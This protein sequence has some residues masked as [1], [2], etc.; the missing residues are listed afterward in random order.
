ASELVALRGGK[1]W[2][3]TYRPLDL[4]S[5]ETGAA[6]LREGGL[7][8]VTGGFGGLGSAMAEE[9]ARRAHARLALVSRR[10]L[11]PP[12][13]Y[14]DAVAD[15]ET[16]PE[17]LEAIGTIRRLERLGAEVIPICADV[18]N[19]ERMR[20]LIEGLRRRYGRIAGVLHAAGTIQDELIELKSISAI[21]DVFTA[22]IHGTYVLE[23]LLLRHEDPPD[24]FVLFS[25]TSSDTAPRGQA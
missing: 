21:A 13:H 4:P 16:S 14:D 24:F 23:R 19:L 1:R 11:P 9:L 7:Y 6:L 18:S 17:V 22:K 25:S 10:V 2:L 20:E 15:P 8:L 3:R 12:E 5:A